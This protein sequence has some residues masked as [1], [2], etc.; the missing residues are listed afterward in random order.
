MPHGYFVAVLHSLLFGV[1]EHINGRLIVV[2][3]EMPL[4][5]LSLSSYPH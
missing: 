5:F 2:K 1:Y 4:K 3:T